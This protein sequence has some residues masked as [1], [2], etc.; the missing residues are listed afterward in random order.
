[1]L[2][3]AAMDG[4][5]LHNRVMAYTLGMLYA[6]YF[7]WHFSS[8]ERCVGDAADEQQCF[9]QGINAGR[10]WQSNLLVVL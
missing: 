2:A 5:Q 7:V 1:M 10:L 9:L 8:L 4:Q 3:P 6:L